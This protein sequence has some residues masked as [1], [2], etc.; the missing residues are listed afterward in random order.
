MASDKI[1][2]DFSVPEETR[3]F[4][5]K[6]RP[7]LECVLLGPAFLIGVYFLIFKEEFP[8]KVLGLIACAVSGTFLYLNYKILVTRDA[9]LLI[10]N[11]GM[12]TPGTDFSTWAEIRDERITTETIKSNTYYY[13]NYKFP[14]GSQELLINGLDFTPREI[15]KIINVYRRRSQ[16]YDMAALAERL[17]KRATEA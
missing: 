5:T 6:R 1:I 2:T 13:L 3:V 7:I 12:Q 11:S 10:T 4:Y 16:N 8:E 15:E 9:R 17:E 14:K